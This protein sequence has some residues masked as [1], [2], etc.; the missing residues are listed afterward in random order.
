M[1]GYSH[2]CLTTYHSNMLPISLEGRNCS[3][4]QWGDEAEILLHAVP[5][6]NVLFM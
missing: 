5:E 3:A 1:T 2:P 6:V 4:R